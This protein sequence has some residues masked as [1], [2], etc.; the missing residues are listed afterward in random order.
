MKYITILIFIILS[1]FTYGQA[2]SW[3]DFLINIEF[4]QSI[5]VEQIEVAYYQ[6]AGQHIEKIKFK[7]DSLKSTIE[8]SGHHS[9]VVGA[10][11]P[12]VV[13]SYKE[14]ILN[15]SNH[16]S[17]TDIEE[18]IEIENLYY[19]IIQKDSFST[20]D[21]DFHFNLKFSNE[22]P[23]III[24]YENISGKLKYNVSNEPD[25]FLP[26]NEMRISNKLI[27]VKKTIE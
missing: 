19:L 4:E 17:I 1:N 23:N 18:V 21:E 20:S 6:S 2:S 10:G 25:Y 16:N 22:K 11:F 27:K 24:R 13:F 15:D 5:P 12:V 26:I 3:G 7:T 14:R 9:F 8:I